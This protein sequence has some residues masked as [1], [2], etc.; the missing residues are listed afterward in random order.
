MKF[1][2]KGEK[3]MDIDVSIPRTCLPQIGAHLE[4]SGF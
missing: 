3:F 2:F 1:T 4:P